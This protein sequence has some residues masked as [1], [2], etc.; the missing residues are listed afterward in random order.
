M[1][2]GIEVRSEAAVSAPSRLHHKQSIQGSHQAA[3][4][5]RAPPEVP[6]LPSAL[7]PP[8]GAACVGTAFASAAA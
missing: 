7:R 5:D 6:A 1:G 8:P 3:L 4:D 2:V